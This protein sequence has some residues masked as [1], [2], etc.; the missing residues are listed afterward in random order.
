M[1]FSVLNKEEPL[2]SGH[3]HEGGILPFSEIG[4]RSEGKRR[5]QKPFHIQH[6]QLHDREQISSNRIL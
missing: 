4:S 2:P 5:R 3:G 6:M 1:H